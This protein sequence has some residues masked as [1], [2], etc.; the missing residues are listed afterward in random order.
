MQELF[1]CFR[2]LTMVYISFPLRK[3]F[4]YSACEWHLVLD[5]Q[6]QLWHHAIMHS[7][8]TQKGKK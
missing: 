1:R 7:Y 6:P 3:K 4:G 2:S 5:F 8:G